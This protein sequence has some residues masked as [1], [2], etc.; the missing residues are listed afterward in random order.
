MVKHEFLIYSLGVILWILC[1]DPYWRA[2]LDLVRV[3][4]LGLLER[5]CV[6]VPSWLGVANSYG[7][8]QKFTSVIL[9]LVA[10]TCVA[11]FPCLG[12][13]EPLCWV[14]ICCSDLKDGQ[15]TRSLTAL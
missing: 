12:C 4:L 3:Y 9:G 5:C 8:F 14:V 1:H 6:L 11:L 10:Q 7:T 2:R 13:P 15:K